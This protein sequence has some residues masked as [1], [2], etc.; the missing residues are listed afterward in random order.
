L[1]ANL[2][3]IPAANVPSANK[4]GSNGSQCSLG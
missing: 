4:N 1:I 3:I 2:K